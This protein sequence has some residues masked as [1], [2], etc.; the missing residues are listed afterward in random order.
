MRGEIPRVAERVDEVAHTITPEHISGW[1]GLL[2]T[3]CNSLLVCGIDV[4]DIDIEARI[5]ELGCLYRRREFAEDDLGCTV[6]ESSMHDFN[7]C[8][9][10]TA[11]MV[12]GTNRLSL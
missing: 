1:H 12:L 5:R 11:G 10:G 4:G 9:L 7:G 3:P 8:R 2:H 6:L